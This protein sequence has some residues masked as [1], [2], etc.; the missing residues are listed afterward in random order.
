MDGTVDA[1]QPGKSTLPPDY[2]NEL[3]ASFSSMKFEPGML[4]GKHVKSRFEVEVSAMFAPEIIE[5]RTL[6]DDQRPL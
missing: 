6:N 4:H 5:S 2:V 1:V 3:K